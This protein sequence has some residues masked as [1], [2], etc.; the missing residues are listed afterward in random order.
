MSVYNVQ[1]IIMYC[2][3]SD[4]SHD[5]SATLRP[6]YFGETASMI[7]HRHLHYYHLA[8]L[9]RET[10]QYFGSNRHD[11][12]GPFYCGMDRVLAML[13]FSLIM[14]CPLSTSIQIEVATKFAGRGGIL[15]QLKND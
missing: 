14:N 5:F 12:T 13:S 15:L 9:L 11:A 3:F 10:V 8:K 6:L 1:S 7:T 2:D 4:L